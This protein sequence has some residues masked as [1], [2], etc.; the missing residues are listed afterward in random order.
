MTVMSWSLECFS[1]SVA[2]MVYFFYGDDHTLQNRVVFL[3]LLTHLLYFVIIP[4]SYLLNTEVCKAF[5]CAHGW[6]KSF[7]TFL[8][9]PRINPEQP[10]ELELS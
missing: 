10:E 5:V 9:S 3:L 1:G 2:L 7:K 4:G 6:W 8:H